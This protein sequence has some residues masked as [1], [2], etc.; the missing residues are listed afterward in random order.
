[1]KIPLLQN[2]GSSAIKQDN[3]LHDIMPRDSFFA[4]LKSFITF[5]DV[6]LHQALGTGLQFYYLK[7][8]LQ[9]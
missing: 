6:Y 2:K 8:I 5:L 1:M 7:S 3:V 9:L 4:M